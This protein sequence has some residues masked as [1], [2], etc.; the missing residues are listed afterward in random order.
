MKMEVLLEA[1]IENVEKLE[2]AAEPVF[3]ANRGLYGFERCPM[4]MI[5]SS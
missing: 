1:L 2:V 5:R 4:R 3:G